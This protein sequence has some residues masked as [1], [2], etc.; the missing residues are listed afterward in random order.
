MI[1]TED[2]N[3]SYLTDKPKVVTDKDQATF[4]IIDRIGECINRLHIKMLKM[5]KQNKISNVCLRQS[6]PKK[7]TLVGSSRSKR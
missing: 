4:K 6:H 3:A 2:K 5:P 7:L 1:Q